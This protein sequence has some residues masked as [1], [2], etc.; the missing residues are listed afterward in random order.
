M[1]RPLVSVVLPTFNGSRFIREAID[2]L[3]VQTYTNWELVLVDDASTD[4]TP[5]ILAGYARAD[6]R[7][8]VVRNECNLRLPQS[9]NKGFS[10]SRGALLTWT[11]D[12]NRHRPH[13]LEVMVDAL[14]TR[15][16]VGMVYTDYTDITEDGL[17][18]RA[19]ITRDPR[20][21]TCGNCINCSFMYRRVVMESIGGYDSTAELVEDYD[22]WVRVSKSFALLRLPVDV[23]LYRQHSS[24]LSTTRHAEVSRAV[25][26]LMNRHLRDRRFFDA[27][28]RAEGFLAL[29]HKA[30]YE[31]RPIDA[32]RYYW[33]AFRQNPFFV[34]RNGRALLIAGLFGQ[35]AARLADGAYRVARR[36]SAKR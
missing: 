13:A 10:L 8:T 33:A 30:N 29:M 21:L 12:D 17:E 23:Y 11:S 7:I 27:Q 25:E 5:E 15:P 20:H 4:G 26:R 32:R 3:V 35:R 18:M 6:P 16:D 36:Q 9:L 28:A 22:Y 19:V 34:L 1:T 24:S 14:E 2:S 31:S